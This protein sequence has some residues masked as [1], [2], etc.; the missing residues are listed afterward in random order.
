MDPAGALQA[1]TRGRPAGIVAPAALGS[2]LGNLAGAQQQ[3][4]AGSD[5]DTLTRG[6]CIQVGRGDG[7]TRFQPGPAL[8][9]GEIQQ[10]TAANNPVGGLGD[11]VL[12]SALAAHQGRLV[13][14]VHLVLE[15]DVGQGVPLGPRLEREDEQVVGPAQVL[16][17]APIEVADHRAGDG[18]VAVPHHQVDGVEAAEPARLGAGLIQR[19]AAGDDLA[20]PDQG[21]GGGDVLGP[22][23]VEGAELVVVTPAAPVGVAATQLPDRFDSGLSLD[24]VAHGAHSSRSRTESYLVTGPIASL[25]MR[26]SITVTESLRRALSK[27]SPNSGPVLTRCP[28]TPNARAMAA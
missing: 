12:E 4:I 18:V 2:A 21:G 14:V 10:H 8:G 22:D 9:P 7:L 1:Q 28:S 23:V 27:T 26:E 16:V 6:A 5:L 11:V 15:H 19:Q 20:R 3:D 25:A 17:L 24:R 13:A